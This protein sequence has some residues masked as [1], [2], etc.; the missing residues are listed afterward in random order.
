MKNMWGDEKPA[1]Q[2]YKS[3]SRMGHL[4]TK[5]GDQSCKHAELIS[6]KVHKD[7]FKSLLVPKKVDL[8]IKQGD[9][10]AKMKKEKMFDMLR[11][12]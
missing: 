1:Q 12:K 9:R 2:R 8:A 11:E 4:T 7:Q 6:Y 5:N 3:G 10:A